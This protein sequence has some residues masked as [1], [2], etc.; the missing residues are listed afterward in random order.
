MTI[1]NDTN[2][3]FREFLEWDNRQLST[4]V[5]IGWLIFWYYFEAW[6]A[7]L[8]LLVPFLYFWVTKEKQREYLTTVMLRAS[9]FFADGARERDSKESLRTR[10][11]IYD[12][13]SLMLISAPRYK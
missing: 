1:L 4:L 12:T 13:A 3:F 7:P 9:A 5:L 2:T 6:K 10:K 8:A 11:F